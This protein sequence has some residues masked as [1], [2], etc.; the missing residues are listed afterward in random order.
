MAEDTNLQEQQGINDDMSADDF[1]GHE[2][3]DDEK[4]VDDQGRVDEEDG[5]ESEPA[6]D[7][8]EGADT[9]APS[10]EKVKVKFLGQERELTR[11]ELVSAAQKGL[12]YDHVAEERDE[13]KGRVA[14]FDQA[15]KGINI[16]ERYAKAAG[17]SVEQ[18]GD[19]LE[20]QE[21]ENQVKGMAEKGVPEDVARRLVELEAKERQRDTREAEFQHKQQE[22]E[23]Q[24]QQF[25]DFVKEYPEIRDFDKEIPAEVWTS[26]RT[27]TPLVQ[28]YRSWENQELKRQIAAVKKNEENKHKAVG[29]V[30]GDAAGSTKRDPFLDGL[31]GL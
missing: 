8:Q 15:Q 29:S 9:N 25:A 2:E 24:K 23:L 16:L 19:W 30:T 17:M 22:E 18:Y 31:S 7:D 10:P 5:G 20:K 3:L 28:A 1:F 6:E 26:V 14:S 12:N 11:D 4:E 21:Q 13:L 27:G